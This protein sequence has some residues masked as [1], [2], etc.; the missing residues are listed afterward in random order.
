M[1]SITIQGNL[2]ADPETRTVGAKGTT[3]SN[4]NIAVSEYT[5]K[6][7]ASGK[8]IYETFWV[9]ITAWGRLAEAAGRSLKKGNSIVVS[10]RL[11]I[12]SF[13]KKDGTPGQSTEIVADEITKAERLSYGPSASGPAPTS[14]EP[15]FGDDGYSGLEFK[16]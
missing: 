16:D 1:N 8:G 13:T 9:R 10:G 2:G 11:T 15:L 5:G 12:R 4:F 7:D 14:D 3:V 6:K